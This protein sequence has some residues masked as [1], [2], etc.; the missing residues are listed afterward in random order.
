VEE[1]V[2]RLYPDRTGWD[3]VSQDL[4]GRPIVYLRSGQELVFSSFAECQELVST[5]TGILAAE[6]RNRKV[7]REQSR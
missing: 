5:L 6:K 3:T 2:R 7:R 4:R 1:A